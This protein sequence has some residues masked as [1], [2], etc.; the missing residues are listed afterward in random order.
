MKKLLL[1]VCVVITVLFANAD[2]PSKKVLDAFYA[3]FNN[4]KDVN[5]YDVANG[6]EASFTSNNIIYRVIYD[7][8]GNIVQCFR[9]YF[10]K[11]LPLHVTSKLYKKYPGRHI[12]AVVEE[13]DRDE[14]SYDVTL[15]DEKTIVLVHVNSFGN[16]VA[17]QKWRKALP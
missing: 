12:S 8:E 7:S 16:I 2:V 4:V 14:L 3:S 5:W 6:S 17:T 1:T 13:T 10:Q 11:E 15:E 9:Y